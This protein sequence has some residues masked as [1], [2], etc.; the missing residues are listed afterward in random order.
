MPSNLNRNLSL[1]NRI[2]KSSA[3]LNAQ[4]NAQFNNSPANGAGLA[5][6]RRFEGCLLHPYRC[7]AGF[8]TIG[9][10][11]RLA[12]KEYPL[13]IS[14]ISAA[15][16]DA[17]LL[18]DAE[19]AASAARRLTRRALQ[20]QEREALTSFIFNLGPAAYQRSALRLAIERG[21]ANAIHHQWQ[22]WVWAGGRKLPGL[23][24]RRLAEWNL[25][26]TGEA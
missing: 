4:C 8:W 2:E 13:H 15:Q 10:G 5:L 26:H 20:T 17:W 25:Y 21:E 22:R 7:P 9:Y 1:Q 14:G 11:H 19:K 24:T 16:A 3:Q 6:I 18:E 23:L 12:E